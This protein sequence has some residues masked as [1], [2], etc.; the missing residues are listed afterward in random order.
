MALLEELSGCKLLHGFKK[1]SHRIFRL[2]NIAKVLSFLEQRN[3]KLV[4]IDAADVADGHSSIILGLIWNIILFFQI[5]ELTGNIRCQFPSSSSSFTSSSSSFSTTPTSFDLTPPDQLASTAQREQ[6]RAIKKLLHWVQKRTRQFGVAVLDFGRSW[7]SGLVFLAVIK[8]IDPSLVD[9]RKALL[10]SA[11]ENLEEAFRIAHFGLGIPRLLEPEDVIISSPDEQ[12]IM[13]Y[14]SQFLEHFPDMEQAEEPCRLDQRSV[15]LCRLNFHDSDSKHVGNVF[16]RNTMR[17]RSRMFQ[18]DSTRQYSKILVAP[19]PEGSRSMS[20]PLRPLASRSSEDLLRDSSWLSGEEVVD[21]PVCV[22]PSLPCRESSTGSSVLDSLNSESLTCNSALESP[23]SWADSDL[24]VMV[25][26]FGENQSVCSACDS[27][28]AC[29]C[30]KPVESSTLEESFIPSVEEETPPVDNE[31]ATAESGTDEAVD[32]QSSSKRS[33]E[34]VQSYATHQE[35]VEVRREDDCSENQT[36]DSNPVEELTKSNRVEVTNII[37]SEEVD[38]SSCPKDEALREEALPLKPVDAEELISCDD[39]TGA[40]AVSQHF[41]NTEVPTPEKPVEQNV[42]ERVNSETKLLEKADEQNNNNNP[43]HNEAQISGKTENQNEVKLSEDVEPDFKSHIHEAS[44]DLQGSFQP[45]T[46]DSSVKTQSLYQEQPSPTPL[47]PS[48]ARSSALRST[49]TEQEEQDFDRTRDLE[50]NVTKENEDFGCNQTD[51]DDKKEIESRPLFS[52]VIENDEPTTSLSLEDTNRTETNKLSSEDVLPP[53][54]SQIQESTTEPELEESSHARNADKKVNIQTSFGNAESESM[55]TECGT[56]QQDGQQD[57]KMNDGTTYQQDTVDPVDPVPLEQSSL[58]TVS[59]DGLILNDSQIYDSVG[60][61]VEPMDIFYPEKEDPVSSE[62]I[63]MEMQG[64]PLVLSVSAL[65]P[66]PATD[67]LQDAQPLN[68]VEEDLLN[69]ESLSEQ[70]GG[71]EQSLLVLTETGSLLVDGPPDDRGA[72]EREPQ[73][74][75]LAKECTRPVRDIKS[76]NFQDEN[77]IPPVASHRE[78]S[79]IPQPTIN[80]GAPGSRNADKEDSDVWT[81]KDLELHLLLLLWMLLYCFW[82]L[83]RMDVKELPHL[84][85]NL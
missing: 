25:E 55:E 43:L 56:N 49:S 54:E 2:N 62:P 28:V 68:L 26:T 79:D 5:K 4:S 40:T 34:E 14:V 83:P 76:L 6:S 78:D 64:W 70:V 33:Q 47:D 24:A 63:D 82:L 16:N 37:A 42:T 75:A 50:R 71:K 39:G 18:G 7:R 44:S 41:G 57:R 66:A 20:L 45:V 46:S 35:A 73:G 81:S 38:S 21:E 23:D 59:E 19:V 52:P 36:G 65:Q 80:P 61:S 3:V 1:S 84:L 13:M 67:T 85:L 15:S 53:G 9:M 48:H 60:D 11:R 32:F 10:R 69:V 12:S 77:Q 29:D 17:E 22:S 27:G 72:S 74:V 51:V 30:A 31:A 58:R 8:S